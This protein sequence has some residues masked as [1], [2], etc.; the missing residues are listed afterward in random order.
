MAVNRAYN[1]SDYLP[2]IAWG[3]THGFVRELEVGEKLVINGRVQSRTYQKMTEDGE[4]VTKVAYEISINRISREES[5]NDM[6][7]QP[8]ED[9]EQDME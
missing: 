2:C 5:L 4:L 6:G 3:E 7:D 8:E 9:L 1:K